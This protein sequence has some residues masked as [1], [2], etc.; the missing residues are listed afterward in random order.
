MPA[1]PLATTGK[2][3]GENISLL[4]NGLVAYVESC[5]SQLKYKAGNGVGLFKV[6]RDASHRRRSIWGKGRLLQEI[7][8]ER[9]NVGEGLNVAMTRHRPKFLKV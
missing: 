7:V 9:R 4:T 8:R 6:I 5:V 3:D 2:W 1:G